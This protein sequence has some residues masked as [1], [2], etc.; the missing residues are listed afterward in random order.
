MTAIVTALCFLGYF[1][2]YVFYA[3]YLSRKIFVLDESATTPSHELRDEVDYVPTNG[4]AAG[5]A[6]GR[7]RGGVCRLRA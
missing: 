2:G 7:V 4:L 3:R 6:L 1:L 5:D